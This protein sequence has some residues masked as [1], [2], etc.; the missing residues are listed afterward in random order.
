M[1]YKLFFLVCINAIAVCFPYNIIGCAGGDSDP[2]D[3]YVSFF[4]K[5]NSNVQGYSPFYYTDVQFLYEEKEPVT[6][7]DVTAAEWV[8]YG[9]NSFTKK[10]AI[11]FVVKYDRRHLSNLYYHLEKNQ[12]LQL[13]DSISKNGMTNWFM[14]SKDLEA[15]GYIMY[16]KQV[17]PNVTG[18]WSAWEP[19]ARDKEKM[20]KLQKNG[21]QLYNVAKNEFIRLRYAYQVVRLAHYASRYDEAILHYDQLVKPNT[22]KSILQDMSLS[23][24]AGAL[25]RTGKKNEGAYLFSQLFTRNEVMRVS[26]YMSFDWSVKRFDEQNR[27]AV[28]ALCKTDEERANVLGLFA[29]GSDR[30]EL[31]TL[32]SIRKMA[33]NSPMLE[34]LLIRELNKLE[35]N[36]FTPETEAKKKEPLAIRQYY[37]DEGDKATNSWK[38]TIPAFVTLC[39]DAAKQKNITNKGLFSVAAAHALLINKDY[40]GARRQL[41]EAKKISLSSQLQDQWAMTNLLLAINSQPSIDR[42][43]EEQIFPSL[44]WLEKKAATSND[45]ALFYRRIFSDILAPRYQQLNNADQVKYLL[46]VGTAEWVQKTY[47][48]EGW[49]FWLSSTSMLRNDLSAGQIQQLFTLMNNSKLNTLEKFMVSHN[50]F[51]K[52]DVNDITGTALLREFKFAEA[53]KWFAKIPASYYAQEPYSTY[54]TANP[55]ADLIEDTHAPT[56]QDTKKYTKLSFTQKMMQLERDLAKASDPEKKAQ[57]HYELAKG[58]YGMSY[59][60]NSWILSQYGWGGGATFPSDQSSLKPGEKEY[61]GVFKARDHYQQAYTLSKDPNF[62]ARSLFMVAKCEQKQI[63]G[64]VWG[65]NTSYDEYERAKLAQ[66]KKMMSSPHFTT[67]AKQYSNTA[68]YKEAVN[69]CSYLKDFVRKVK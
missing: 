56:P 50:T 45:Y 10:D 40:A 66:Q 18:S 30:S 68:F 22:T 26:N 9:N 4:S 31:K 61:Y 25:T 12:P 39:Q 27:Q 51:N 37:G 15:L 52:D 28:L 19:I 21:L 20:A 8:G 32:Q 14:K 17:E 54:L 36:Y 63:P 33:P 59:W 16:A 67:L 69:T 5:N 64:P 1:K 3:Y 34:I 48:K 55:F 57:L 6:T 7:S 24:K 13:P 29:L 35:D 41:D 53:E 42:S 43:F 46:C 49:G 65:R 38:A 11:D 47:V 44:Q 60:G 2:Y 23:L 62:K 58:M